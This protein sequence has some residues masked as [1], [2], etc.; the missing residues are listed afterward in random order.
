ML[1]MHRSGAGLGLIIELG[2]GLKRWR[3]MRSSS[4]PARNCDGVCPGAHLSHAG[5]TGGSVLRPEGRGKPTLRVRETAPHSFRCP[6]SF[7]TGALPE[8]L[9]RLGECCRCQ[10]AGA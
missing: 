2:C 3:A 5:R 7:E 10:V 4:G 6:G 8:A 9:L 1:W